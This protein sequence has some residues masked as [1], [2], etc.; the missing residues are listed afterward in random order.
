MD[1][2]DQ[3]DDDLLPSKSELKRAAKAQQAL[4]ERL[5]GLPASELEELP[6]PDKLRDAV[7]LARRIK[8]RSGLR[9]QRQY[10][11]KLMRELDTAALEQAFARRD[12]AA[13]TERRRFHELEALRDR[14]VEDEANL[15][16]VIA[17]W[18]QAELQPLRQLARSARAER[19]QGKPP[20]K[21]RKLFRALRTLAE[22]ADDSAG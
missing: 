18:P 11:G 7:S 19:D 1:D 14:L 2:R 9:R 12:V 20:A 3:H 4:G 15:G 10:I 8:D 13:E 5:I 17:R 6:L 16:E 21:A 22:A